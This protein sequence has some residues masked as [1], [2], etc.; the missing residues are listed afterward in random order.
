VPEPSVANG[1][2]AGRAAIVVGA[3]SAGPGWGNGKATAVLF[4]REGARVLCLD[5]DELAARETAAIIRGEGG[6]AEPCTGDASRAADVERAVARCVE[7]FGGLDILDNNVGIFEE[8]GV[9]DLPEE[10]WNRVL[11]VN[12][13]SFFLTM[14]HAVPA[15][16]RRGGGAI[17]NISSITS[18]LHTGPGSPSIA[19]STTKAAVNHLTSTAAIECAPKG[20]RVN[21]ILPGL[22]KTPM[23]D[24]M[25]DELVAGYG[26]ADAE[27]LERARD[28]QCPLGYQGD[29]WDVARAAVFLASAD[30]RYITGAALVVDGG[31]TLMCN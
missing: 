13:T 14:K 31:L 12:L 4:A 18:L 2:L 16:E 24:A 22:M 9:V 29:A 19:Y 6:V 15:M 26:V 30:A 17:V 28:A 8:G 20:I 7:R 10:R 1:R 3:G 21:A 11:A 5:V 25:R 23:V 27:Q